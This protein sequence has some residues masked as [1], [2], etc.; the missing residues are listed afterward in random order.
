MLTT[1]PTGAKRLGSSGSVVSSRT[2]NG[3]SDA[4]ATANGLLLPLSVS[5]LGQSGAVSAVPS[6]TSAPVSLPLAPLPLPLPRCRSCNCKNSK[7]L[8]L[9]CEC[10]AAGIYCDECNCKHCHNNIQHEAERK[11][12]IEVTL[13]RNPRAFRPKIAV[14]A[15]ASPKH[16]TAAAAANSRSHHSHGAG[17]G[18]SGRTTAASRDEQSQLLDDSLQGYY[19]SVTAVRQVHHK[20]CHCKKSFCLKKY[21]EVC[22]AAAPAN[23]PA[24]QPATHECRAAVSVRCLIHRSFC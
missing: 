17:K 23:Q 21:C 11:Q 3:A 13:E 8:K 15:T 1:S 16:S 2:A 7:C 9:Y 18:D 10:F 12:A 19:E 22:R 6:L 4:A 24:S 5:S 20:G 14:T